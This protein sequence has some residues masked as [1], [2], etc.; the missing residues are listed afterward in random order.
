[1]TE[2]KDHELF[3]SYEGVEG[4]SFS[5]VRND[6]LEVVRLVNECLELELQMSTVQSVGMVGRSFLLRSSVFI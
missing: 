3:K 5:V 1:M 4:M 2:I 6:S